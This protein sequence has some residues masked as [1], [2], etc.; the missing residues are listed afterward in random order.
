M[1]DKKNIDPQEELDKAVAQEL[2][3][4]LQSMTEDRSKK[5]EAAKNQL[6]ESLKV[7]A[8]KYRTATGVMEALRVLRM[9]NDSSCDG[10]FDTAKTLASWMVNEVNKLTDKAEKLSFAEMDQLCDGAYETDFISIDEFNSLDLAF[11]LMR[12]DLCRNVGPAAEDMIE[13][14]KRVDEEINQT[15]SKLNELYKKYPKFKNL[16]PSKKEK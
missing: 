4:K 16:K 12:L 1:A 6:I 8:D 7:T 10:E 5:C 3:D 2:V 11:E 15:E 9:V 13:F 14:Q